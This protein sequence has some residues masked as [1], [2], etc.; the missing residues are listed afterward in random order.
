MMIV[1]KTHD[2]NEGILGNR[3]AS[4]DVDELQVEMYRHTALAIRDVGLCK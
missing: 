2:I 1:G 3:L 4:V